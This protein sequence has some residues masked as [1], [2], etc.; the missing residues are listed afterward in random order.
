METKKLPTVECQ[1]MI[2]KPVAEVFE[3]FIDPT[4]TTRFWFTKSSGKLEEGKA[5]KW[6]WE[7]YNVSSDVFVKEIIPD[8][9]I[10]IEWDDPATTVDFEFTALTG[11]TTYVIIK[12]YGFLQAGDDLIQAIKD[13][14]GGF[15][16]VLDGLKAWLEFGIELNLVRDKF[17]QT[18][19]K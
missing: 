9:K 1:M 15:T 8:K 18:K 19:Q 6:Q 2:R 13:N 10:S 4:I 14:T 12:N 7:M 5:I 11:N 16:T 17:P 3:A